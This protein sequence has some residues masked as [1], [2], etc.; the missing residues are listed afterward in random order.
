[1][2][3]NYTQYNTGYGYSYSPPTTSTRNRYMSPARWAVVGIYGGA[4]IYGFTKAGPAGAA[5]SLI[6]VPEFITVPL[7]V[8]G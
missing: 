1:V 6:A 8:M 4:A 2:L 3:I 5:V 7:W